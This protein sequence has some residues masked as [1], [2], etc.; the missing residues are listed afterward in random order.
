MAFLTTRLRPTQKSWKC[1]HGGAGTP[2][3][4]TPLMWHLVLPF[5]AV[6][7]FPVKGQTLY[8]IHYYT[9][10]FTAP[11]NVT[12]PPFYYMCCY[13]FQKVCTK[14]LETIHL[15]CHKGKLY[16]TDTFP[17]LVITLPIRL[18]CGCFVFVRLNCV[19]LQQSIDFS[20]RVF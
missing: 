19:K 11:R 20:K 17:R 3:I 15:W 2:Q 4:G 10:V 1:V 12:S 5:C 14:I 16:F 8:N 7:S 9:K 13:I 6:F 18:A